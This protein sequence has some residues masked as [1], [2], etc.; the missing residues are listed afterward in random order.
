M[1]QALH[2]L[3]KLTLK[4]LAQKAQSLFIILVMKDAVKLD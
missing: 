2:N 3:P 4:V 1:T